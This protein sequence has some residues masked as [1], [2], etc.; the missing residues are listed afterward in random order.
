MRMYTGLFT[1]DACMLHVTPEG[2]PEQATRLS[3]VLNALNK[4]EFEDLLYF[5]SK[6]AHLDSIYAVHPKTFIDFLHSSVPQN[7]RLLSIDPDTYLSQGSWLAALHSSGAVI[8]AIDAVMARNITNAF[9]AIRPPGHHAEPTTS[10]GFCLWN[11]I[12]IGAHHARMKHDLQRVA[13]IDFDVHHGNG[14]QKICEKDPGLFYASVHEMPLYPGSGY[15]DERG[16]W[17]QCLNIPL[18]PGSGSAEFRAAMKII[19][20]EIIHFAPEF[21]LISAGFDAHEKDPLATLNLRDDDFYWATNMLTDIASE[22][23]NGRIVSSLEG[24]YDEGALASA[25]GSHV[26]ALMHASSK[27]TST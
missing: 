2:H 6:A 3:A 23:C 27:E 12:A 10:M 7:E 22:I 15:P 11:H 24:G 26:R 1:H 8:D 9:C 18:S 4:P 19:G 20:Q 16:P 25:V 21:L 14:T 5:T 13:I 17:H